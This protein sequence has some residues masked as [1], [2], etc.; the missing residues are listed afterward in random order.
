MG[1]LPY[2]PLPKRGNH[3]RERIAART[4]HYPSNNVKAQNFAQ[5]ASFSA[6]AENPAATG[7]LRWQGSNLRMRESKSRAFTTW[8]HLIMGAIGLEPMTNRL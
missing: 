7:E 2:A 5:D 3:H 1:W 6:F 4:P 8:R